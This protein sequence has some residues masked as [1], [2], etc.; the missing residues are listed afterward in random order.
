MLLPFLPLLVTPSPTRAQAPLYARGFGVRSSPSGVILEVTIP[1]GRG[2]SEGKGWTQRWLLYPREAGTSGKAPQTHDSGGE[3]RGTTAERPRLLAVPVTRVVVL[4]TTVLPAFSELGGLGS[5]VAVQEGGWVQ[6]PAIRQL[7]RAGVMESLGE[8]W[9]PERVVRLNPDLVLAYA[10]GDPYFDRYLL[11]E[12]LGIPV[13]LI[14]DFLEPTPLGRAEWM[15]V[16]A[17]LLGKGREG[18]SLF[19]R[20]ATAY[21]AAK[22]PAPGKG[23]PV[24]V[25]SQ[26][27]GVWYLPAQSGFL[28]TLIQDAGGELLSSGKEGSGRTIDQ[29]EL[30]LLGQKAEV[31]LLPQFVEEV[32]RL[33]LPPLNRIPAVTQ[34]RVYG[35]KG[36]DFWERGVL[37]PEELLKELLAI[38]T[39]PQPL[40]GLHYFAPVQGG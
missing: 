19:S 24:L 31:W 10:V 36:R 23:V 9:D 35:L 16:I 32:P 20:I 39:R 12:R 33:F 15:K 11:L 34:G 25:A 21:E 38:F 27:Q 37:H 6:D 2:I 22:R 13:L 18:E 3:G 28:R 5:L 7:L 14:Q 40:S 30:F 29:E 1:E 17:L 8:N 4:T 26:F